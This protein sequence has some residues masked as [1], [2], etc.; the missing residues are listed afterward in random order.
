MKISDQQDRDRNTEPSSPGRRTFVKGIA[1]VGAG[2]ATF[3]LLTNTADAQFQA[4]LDKRTP[5]G[6]SR[7]EVENQAP[8][9]FQGD[10]IDWH[11]FDRYDF[12]MDMQTLA[13]R[14]FKPPAGEESGNLGESNK[15]QLR[16]VV[17]VPKKAAPGK[18][19]SWRGVYW[20]H[21]PQAEVELLSRGFHIA[22]ISVDP[23]PGSLTNLTMDELMDQL[24][25]SQRALGEWDA[26]YAF[27]TGQYGLSKKPAFV[28]MSR[29]GIFEY[30]WGSANPDKVSCIYADNP[31]M[32]REGFQRL[33]DL[34]RADVPVLQICGT[35][36]PLL[37]PYTS[38]IEAIYQQFG[39]RISMMIKEGYAHHPH[40]LRNPKP[41]ADFIEQSIQEVRGPTPAFAGDRFRKTSYYGTEN[42]YRNYP[43]EDT[44]LTCRGPLFS[45]CYD[46]YEFSV[47]DTPMSITVIAP[48]ASAPGMP[49]VYRAGFVFRDAKVDQQLL[50]KG[51]HIVTGPVG[52]DFAVKN[53]DT[54]Y[55]YLTMH[56]FSKKPA[57]EGAGGGAGEVYA[58]AIE[59]PDK[60]SCIYAENPRMH[61]ALAKTQ[62][63]D[64][65]APLAKA[66]V[67][68]L[69][70]CGSL[71][72]WFNDNTLEVEKRYK[73][74]GGKIEVIVKKGA[75]HYPLAPEDPAP[76]VNF[77]TRVA[78]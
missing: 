60:V 70:V 6:S 63:L 21:Q 3:P 29:G 62:P 55:E 56:G 13:I 20:N 54:V 19:W 35:L 49:W 37:G 73:K 16:C 36:D 24:G 27:L 25:M 61:S 34:A 47:R 50:A 74:L 32:V 26:W 22:Y 75:G 77:I 68:L 11:G 1:A 78:T 53:W 2:V 48:S 76:V 7:A 31:G 64:N 52:V 8:L 40:S 43:E 59:N 72:P 33:V 12:V 14:P 46:R 38:A 51:F 39:G 28:G 30:Q 44:Y 41:I 71:D 42:V 69:H 45:P 9:A 15:G 23:K 66:N 67:P 4:A 57:M 5:S 10:K 65:L 17:V 18:P 58:W